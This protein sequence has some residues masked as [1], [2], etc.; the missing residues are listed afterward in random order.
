VVNLTW[1][2]VNTWRLSQQS[3]THRLPHLELVEAVR[4]TM[5][6]HAQV[7]SAAELAIAA[8]VDGITSPDVQSALWRDRTLVKTWMIRL[9]SYLFPTQDFPVFVAARRI[10]DLDWPSVFNKSGIDRATLDAYLAAA[11]EILERGP[12]TRRQFFEAISAQLKSTELSDFLRKD[13]WGTALK[14]LALHG[15]LCY[16]PND[17][18]DATFIRPSAWIGSWQAPDPEAA[19]REIVHHYL[20]AFGPVRPRNFQVWWW[21]SGV[22]AKKAFNAIA[23]ETEEVVVEGWHATALKSA[24]QAMQELEPTGEVRL[25]PAF[26]VFTVGL[27]RGKDLEKLFTLEQQK[28]IYRPQGWVSAIVLVDGSIKGLW[29]HKVNRSALSVTVDLFSPISERIKEGIA[30]EAGR[31]GK[32]LNSNVQL[33][34]KQD[35]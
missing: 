18:K 27:A 30:V 31:L 7:M 8:R 32:F 16:G 33:K 17:G 10:T 28:K 22:S 23:Y 19:M 5:G 3:L 20:L 2:Q 13:S 12:I 1:K 11:P 21:M 9:T 15:D 24:V 14:P 34:F 6:V 4:S 35:E 26:D 29:E 25:L